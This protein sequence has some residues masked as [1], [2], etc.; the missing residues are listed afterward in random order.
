MREIGWRKVLPR[1]S[2][3]LVSPGLPGLLVATRLPVGLI[4]K[5][6]PP[7]EFL[8]EAHL[9]KKPSGRKVLWASFGDCYCRPKRTTEKKETDS[10]FWFSSIS[11]SGFELQVR[12][13]F[14]L[15]VLLMSCKWCNDGIP[16]LVLVFL[17]CKQIESVSQFTPSTW[18]PQYSITTVFTSIISKTSLPVYFAKVAS[19]RSPSRKQ[20]H[21]RALKRK[22]AHGLVSRFYCILYN[23]ARPKH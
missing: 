23:L 16:Y 15:S 12:P 7:L 2:Q 20:A 3:K 22:V 18:H 5:T 13:K 21:P 4:S 10:G 8:K 6:S 14:F 17:A 9:Q 11:I 19:K 1:V